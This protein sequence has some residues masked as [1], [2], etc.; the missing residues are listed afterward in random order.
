MVLLL[1]QI[2]VI[3]SIFRGY[4]T[5]RGAGIVKAPFEKGYYGGV[6][7]SQQMAL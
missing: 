3:E 2:F 1:I 6:T 4:S 7:L 5:F